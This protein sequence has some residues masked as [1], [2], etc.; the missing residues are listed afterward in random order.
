MCGRFAQG[1]MDAIYKKYKVAITNY[2]IKKIKPRYNIAPAQNVPVVYNDKGNKLVSMRW[3]LIPHWAKDP[4]IGYKFINARSETVHE[5]PAFKKSFQN[6]RCIVPAS[7]FY[8]WY[9]SGKDRYPHYIYHKSGDIFSFAGIYDIWTDVEGRNFK[10]FAI[11]TTEA[12]KI[13]EPIHDR[14]PVILEKDEEK[15][16]LN[17]DLND[18][19]ELT[20][21]FDPYPEDLMVEHEVSRDVNSIRNEGVE[22]IKQKSKSTLL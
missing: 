3:G 4:K 15:I 11:L 10:T 1:D 20:S 2:L 8:E 13:I 14:M 19:D 6:M 12:N 16:W 9:R 7:G 18:L 17:D 22:L 5:K 21:L